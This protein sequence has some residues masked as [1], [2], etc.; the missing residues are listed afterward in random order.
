MKTLRI[1]L[2]LF[3]AAALLAA[4]DKTPTPIPRHF[5]PRIVHLVDPVPVNST[6]R[7][8]TVYD[9]KN[10]QSTSLAL[11]S[12]GNPH[13]AYGGDRLYYAWFDGATWQHEVADTTHGVG[14]NVHIV[15]DAGDQPHLLYGAGFI[16][17]MAL[18]HTY[19]NQAG[20]QHETIFPPF[21]NKEVTDAAFDPQGR[22]VVVFAGDLPCHS[23]DVGGSHIWYAQQA[24]TRWEITRINVSGSAPALAFDAS[25]QPLISFYD[26]ARYTLDVA[27][28]RGS[29]WVVDEAVNKVNAAPASL[30][31]SDVDGLPHIIFYDWTDE[32]S[33]QHAW[34]DSAGWHVETIQSPSLVHQVGLAHPNMKIDCKGRTH[35]ISVDYQSQVLD[36]A[37]R[38]GNVWHHT[39]ID[40]GSR[41]DWPRADL[42]FD[43][44]GQ[45]VTSFYSSD[46]SIHYMWKEDGT[47]HAETVGAG[48]NSDT[49]FPIDL[50]FDPENRPHLFYIGP[51]TGYSD[52]NLVHAVRENGRWT[53]EPLPVWV[54][55]DLS[56]SHPAI[57]P[58]GWPVLL[59]G[60]KVYSKAVPTIMYRTPAGW[61]SQN[62][63]AVHYKKA[64]EAPP[65][66]AYSPLTAGL[67]TPEAG[68]A[69]PAFVYTTAGTDEVA[70]FDP[71][72]NKEEIVPALDT[73]QYASRYAL[74]FDPQGR[75]VIM[76]DEFTLYHGS[77]IAQKLLFYIT[78]TGDGWQAY[79]LNDVG[80]SFVTAPFLDGQ[81]QAHFA[82][83]TTYVTGSGADWKTTPIHAEGYEFIQGDLR[84]VAQ[85][86]REDGTFCVEYYDY[87]GNDLVVGCLDSIE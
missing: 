34:K 59:F 67:P 53:V 54:Y 50:F 68:I 36:Y 37:L 42:A 39:I 29:D 49:N 35:S 30:P 84:P 1:L 14:S 47:W 7:F 10:I 65:Q 74:D 3:A 64:D 43:P 40:Q 86:L 55:S 26:P 70:Y 48:Q 61:T 15:L 18:V 5:D 79:Q 41:P 77:P 21:C 85:A 33:Y 62:L 75:P 58:E 72:K 69:L 27:V 24:P 51:S 2:L 76:L 22:L 83:K 6:W 81:G 60:G 17:D 25:G 12:Q 4:C 11:D 73:N 31:F 80:A 57:S 16:D 56:W 78:Q 23:S 9:S 52:P 71:Q 20:W 38:E 44:A 87:I 32:N 82:R 8:E 46:E 28:R 45:L 66:I 19:R 13:I 63:A